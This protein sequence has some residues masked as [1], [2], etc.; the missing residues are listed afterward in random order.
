VSMRVVAID[1]PVGSG[2]STVARAVARRLGMDY[3]DT[4][5]MYRSVALAAL[6]QGIDPES[7]DGEALAR[8]AARLQLDV[9]ERVVLDGE[10][11]TDQLRTPDVG[12]AVSAVAAK[13]EVR[14]ELVRR[15]R[16]WA[17]SHGGGVVEG[18][19]I[20]SVVFPDARLKVFLTASDEERARRRASDEDAEALARRDRLDST[21]STS[22]LSVADGAVVVDSTDR[23]VDDVVDEIVGR[24]TG[25]E[26]REAT[27]SAAPPAPEPVAEAAG[28][29]E[30]SARAE[31]DEGPTPQYG[32]P[33]PLAIGMYRAVRGAIHGLARLLFRITY[34]G[35]ENVPTSGVFIVAP[36]HRSNI[37]FGLV[38]VL[39]KRRMRYMGKEALWKYAWFGKLITTLGAFP[40][41]RG[42]ADRE[43]LHRCMEVLRGGEPLVL[44]PEGTRRSGPLV[45]DLY[46][47]A[48]YVAIR[49]QSPLVPVGIGG[50]ERALPK[51]AKI[52]RPVKIHVVVGPPMQPPP[53]KANGHPSR[54]DVRELTGALQAELQRL[55]DHARIAAGDF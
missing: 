28:G 15:Q 3:L 36:V 6:R 37:D 5:A 4:G 33:T 14:E 13:P 26:E 23:S 31:R 35:L 1:G 44:F 42:A 39:T 53:A 22:P 25:E 8:V 47:G 11:V 34:E 43:A 29:D 27:A 24:F 45:K 18:R 7:A 9:G 32:P 30:R 16:E 54:R 2:K 50:S 46:E 10:D 20:G 38:S 48:A 21:R 51:G 12:R 41:R 49:T 52:I 40:V 17:R 55:L 19:D